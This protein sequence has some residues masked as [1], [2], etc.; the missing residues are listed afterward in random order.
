MRIERV[1]V[2][3]SPLICL[4]ESGL[5][6]LFPA[7]FTEIIVPDKVYKEVISKEDPVFKTL[8]SKSGFKHVDNVIIPPSV[9][10]WDLGEGESSVISFALK[11]PQYWAVI[12]DKEARRCAA[13][14]GCR[15]TGTVGIILL[16]KR[17]GI[18]PSVYECL[19]KLQKAGLWL[20]EVF[21]KEVCRKA[22]EGGKLNV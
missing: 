3:T 15:F 12:D 14:L 2:N 11:N 16:A 18:I 9:M 10:S 1:A 13:S 6:D 7:L 17:R 19:K 5:S 21:V 8:F 22:N 4:F 20:S